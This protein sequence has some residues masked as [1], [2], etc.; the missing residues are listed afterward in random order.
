MQSI[1]KI[2]H[3]I[4]KII[5][6]I[7]A[8]FSFALLIITFAK[9]DW[10]KSAIE[11]I[12]QL[13]ETIGIWNYFIAFASACIESLPIIGTTFPG[14]NIMILVGGFWGKTHLFLTILLASI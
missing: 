7:L 9:P 11:W 5:T 3:L 6:I 10:I 4:A 13:I 12:G 8:I 14:M 2:F 1:K